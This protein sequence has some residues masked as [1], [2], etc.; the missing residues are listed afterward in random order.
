MIRR[1]PRSTLFPYTTLFRSGADVKD[2]DNDGWVDVF[3]NNLMGQTWALFR[4]QRGKSFQYV[5]PVTKILMLSGSLTG[6]SNGF[7]DYN[8]DGW[9]D[10]YSANG[11]IDDLESNSRQHDTMFENAGGK[12]FLD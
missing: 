7:I 5:S 1:P 12:E 11:D 6:W 3:Y 2:F 10:L 8:N 9:K 4:N